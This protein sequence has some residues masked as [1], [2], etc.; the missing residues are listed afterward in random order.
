MTENS[1]EDLKEKGNALFKQKRYEDAIVFYNK[2]I[3][4]NPNV[5]VLYSNKGTC[6]KCLKQY[7]ECQI[8][9]NSKK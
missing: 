1:W 4:L 2:A 8:I 5:E 3:K 9:K 7:K 6:E